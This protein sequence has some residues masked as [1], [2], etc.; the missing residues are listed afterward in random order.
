MPIP[1]GSSPEAPTPTVTPTM[2]GTARLADPA[3]ITL[4][5]LTSD[6]FGADPFAVGAWNLGYPEVR[7]VTEADPGADGEIDSTSRVG[8]RGITAEIVVVGDGVDTVGVW[9]RRLRALMHPRRRYWLH[10]RRDGWPAERRIQVRPDSLTDAI[11][12]GS[13]VGIATQAGWRAPYGL[14]EST[15]SHTAV[16]TPSGSVEPGKAL[17]WR[18]P[19]GFGAGLASGSATVVVDSESEPTLPSVDVYGPC[20]N[21]VLINLTTGSQFA[22]TSLTL[23]AGQF[24]RVNFRDRMVLLNADTASSRYGDADWTVSSWWAL[25]PGVNQIAF[26]PSG[27]GPG[28]QAVLSWPD[29]WM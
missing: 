20:I 18:F 5:T 11:I 28:C 25:Q 15:A 9:Y 16:I 19:L 6:A 21:P 2:P 7:A 26:T 29:L 17:P 3:G 23:A 10:L 1:A 13:A 12:S 24:I 4:L 14:W 8:A 22:F 27:P